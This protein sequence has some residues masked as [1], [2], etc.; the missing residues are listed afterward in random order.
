MTARR[1]FKGSIGTQRISTGTV[2]PEITRNIRSQMRRLE[3][4]FNKSLNLVEELLPDAL[5]YAVKP[6][7]EESQRLVPVDTGKLKAS[8][9]IRAGLFRGK[10]QVV[11]GYAAADDP[12]YATF[13]HENLAV[14][15][16]S[17]TQAKFLEEA[18]KKFG[19]EILPRTKKYLKDNAGIE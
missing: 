7:F 9:F 14:S 1:V 4:E 15:H 2:G 16:A 10:P 3:Q 11:V 18:I 5:E 17:P 13:V 8:G 19:D 12:N 6:I